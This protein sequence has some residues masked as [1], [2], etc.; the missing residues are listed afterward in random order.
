MKR[1]LSLLLVFMLMLLPCNAMALNWDGNVNTE[2][3]LYT[4]AVEKYSVQH[5]SIGYSSFYSAQNSTIAAGGSTFFAIKLTVPTRTELVTAYGI[6]P[7]ADGARVKVKL[8]GMTPTTITGISRAIVEEASIPVAT[9][10]VQTLYLNADGVW[11]STIRDALWCGYTQTNAP[12]VTASL[13]Y[14]YSLSKINIQN[15]SGSYMVR[16]A[17]DGFLFYNNE[18]SLCF[19]TDNSG[20]VIRTTLDIG[21]ASYA[22]YQ[23]ITGFGVEGDAGYGFYANIVARYFIALGIDVNSLFNGSVYMTAKNI[24]ANFGPSVEVSN[25]ASWGA[26]HVNIPV[27]PIAEV[28]ATGDTPLFGSMLIVFG[29]IAAISFFV[30]KNICVVRYIKRLN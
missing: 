1:I 16:T 30:V 24:R 3:S 7:G 27:T 10:S 22:V 19:H 18:S 11:C 12:S 26:A 25:T 13:N 9:E 2:T 14:D 6:D 17:S 5:D 29:T 20:K 8:A 15:G 28:P 23:T 4:L 21:S